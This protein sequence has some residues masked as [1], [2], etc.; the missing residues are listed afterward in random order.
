M[1]RFSNPDN[2]IMEK[3][4]KIFDLNYNYLTFKFLICYPFMNGFESR[5][6]TYDQ[7][8]LL[9]FWIYIIFV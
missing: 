3:K 5:Y 9:L 1:S 4:K 8:S 6:T 2:P 7:V